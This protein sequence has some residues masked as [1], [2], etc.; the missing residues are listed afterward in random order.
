MSKRD[1]P[2]AGARIEITIAASTLFRQRDAPHAGARI[3]IQHP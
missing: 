2:H 1:A 3:E